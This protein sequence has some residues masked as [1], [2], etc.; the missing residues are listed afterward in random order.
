MEERL[1]DTSCR[2]VKSSRT[3]LTGRSSSVF[4]VATK[5]LPAMNGSPA[6]L[7]RAYLSHSTR[8]WSCTSPKTS[9]IVRESASTFEV[10]RT[11][12]KRKAINVHHRQYGCGSST[13]W[14]VLPSF[15]SPLCEA[16]L[17][18]Q[19]PTKSDA[20]VRVTFVLDPCKDKVHPAEYPLINVCFRTLFLPHLQYLHKDISSKL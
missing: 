1:R 12:Q 16:T 8:S 17:G 11:C 5:L 7:S 15:Q 6:C 13:L 3:M 14:F 20:K 10:C 9:P 2:I 19:Q 18:Q 4:Y